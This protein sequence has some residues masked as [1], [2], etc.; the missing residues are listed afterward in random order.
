MTFNIPTATSGKKVPEIALFA[1]SRF[2]MYL[3]IYVID[4]LFVLDVILN[5]FFSFRNEYDYEVVDMPTIASKYLRGAFML[6][7]ITCIPPRLFLGNETGGSHRLARVLRIGRILKLGKLL[8][9]TRIRRI[10]ETSPFWAWLQEFRSSRFLKLLIGLLWSVHIVACG[11]Y[12][13][14]Y[15]HEDA[16]EFEH[17]VTRRGIREAP[18]L[19]QWAHGMYFV[20]TT[21]TTVGYGDM[22]AGTVVEIIYV[23]FM[24]IVGA[25]VNGIITS[26]IIGVVTHMDRE[27]SQASDMKRLVDDFAHHTDLGG[28]MRHELNEWS[29][30]LKKVK[31]GLD[32]DN[33]NKL[34]NNY[35]PRKLLSKLPDHV[36]GGQLKQN[37][38]LTRPHAFGMHIPTRL[39]LR[40]AISLSQW[41][42]KKQEV[43]Y[44][45]RDYSWNLHLVL[46]GTFAYVAQLDSRAFSIA[47][48]SMRSSRYFG[49]AAPVVERK[50]SI[51]SRFGRRK[52]EDADADDATPNVFPY[53]LFS[54]LSYFGDIELLHGP[55]G[56]ALKPSPRVSFARCESKAG[57]ILLKLAKEDL[58]NIYSE[59]PLFVDVWRAA[60]PIRECHR[61]R[62]LAEMKV[63]RDYLNLA[64]FTIQ[65]NFRRRW[66][67]QLRL[68]EG[69][70][71]VEETKEP[72]PDDQSWE[73]AR[74]HEIIPGACEIPAESTNG[75][76]PDSPVIT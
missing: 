21:F 3:E 57:G 52:S 40:L 15:F 20:L 13:V 64:A 35:L 56:S 41:H 10:L 60:V 19:E 23:S 5:F 27:A 16:N 67:S 44:Y 66:W 29:S 17:W 48:R 50:G 7:F 18:A 22:S 59:Y 30:R 8:R 39:P 53:Q 37:M 71:T 4:S 76:S 26:E 33:M 14:A 62:L 46:E 9:L 47:S 32:A 55:E 74:S 25:I 38:L 73:V 69:W 36:F 61:T 11:L 75:Q 43:V 28:K 70:N 51:T 54:N 1:D 2:W 65:D 68:V 63:G 12:L 6:D 31:Q 34:I 58:S 49:G 72:G 24:M 45:P 42:Y